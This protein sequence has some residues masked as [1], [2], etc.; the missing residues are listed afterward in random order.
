MRSSHVLSRGTSSTICRY[1][2]LYNINTLVYR[3]RV[4]RSVKNAHIILLYRILRLRTEPM[5]NARGRNGT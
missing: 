2:S 5:V 4:Y 1:T 3:G